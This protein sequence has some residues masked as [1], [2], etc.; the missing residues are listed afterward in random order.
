MFTLIYTRINGS[1]N[2]REAGDLRRHRTHFDVIV[3]IIAWITQLS[4]SVFADVVVSYGAVL[5]LSFWWYVNI[6]WDANVFCDWYLSD[7]IRERTIDMYRFFL[8]D[9]GWVLIW[10]SV[11][12]PGH[13]IHWSYIYLHLST[14]LRLYLIIIGARKAIF[15]SNR[16]ANDASKIFLCADEDSGIYQILTQHRSAT[17]ERRASVVLGCSVR[18]NPQKQARGS[19]FITYTNDVAYA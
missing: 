8:R 19:G 10:R 6:F 16:D 11:L 7:K 1:V 12:T 3:M 5:S 4:H 13:V 15:V 2:N 9:Q 18:T 17:C 14:L